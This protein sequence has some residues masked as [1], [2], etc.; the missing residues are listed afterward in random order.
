M[1]DI[2]RFALWLALWAV[3]IVLLFK[4][5]PSADVGSLSYDY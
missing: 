5:G 2:L 1:K 4:C 3:V